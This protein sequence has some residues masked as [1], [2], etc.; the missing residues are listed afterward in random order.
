MLWMP[1]NMVE[2]QV[3]RDWAIE[4]LDGDDQFA[5]GYPVVIVKPLEDGDA[6]IQAVF[7]YTNFNSNNVFV[8][9]ASDSGGFVSPTDVALALYAPFGPPLNVLRVT[10]LVSETNKRS[11]RL[12]EHFGFKHEGTLRDYE[13]VGT[14]TLVYGLTKADFL[15]G[16][17]G[18][19]AADLHA[20]SD[21][22][23]DG[24]RKPVRGG[25]LAA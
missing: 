21:N 1:K 2:V 25:I 20:E 13:S 5:D 24:R 9:G 7:I 3:A 22:Y 17:Y 10:A 23:V 15:G 12:M 11:A 6:T 8:A 16:R 14:E 4:R 19:K 18:R